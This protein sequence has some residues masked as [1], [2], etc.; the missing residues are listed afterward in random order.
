VGLLREENFS[1]KGLIDYNI[2]CLKRSL[3][4]LYT[5]A[6]RSASVATAAPAPG[7]RSASGSVGGRESAS[8]DAAV[9][10]SS[11]SAGSGRR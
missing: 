10:A 1:K 3:R 7:V 6:S 8:P 9:T 5:P 4:A 11:S 2:D